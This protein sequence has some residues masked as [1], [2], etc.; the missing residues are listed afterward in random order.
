[1]RSK[2]SPDVRGYRHTQRSDAARQNP[3]AQTPIDQT[4]PLPLV[5]RASHRH[6][7]PMVDPIFSNKRRRLNRARSMR[8]PADTRWL[9]DRMAED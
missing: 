2:K 5:A 1:M 6:K 4:N 8:A 9:L 3:A 7:Q